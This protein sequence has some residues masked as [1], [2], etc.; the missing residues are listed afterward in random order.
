M[1]TITVVHF[2]ATRKKILAI[3]AATEGKKTQCKLQISGISSG[4]CDA[5]FFF[6]VPGLFEFVI[7]EPFLGLLVGDLRGDAG[8]LSRSV[9]PSPLLVDGRVPFRG[10]FET[11]V[12]V[13]D[14][15]GDSGAVSFV[16]F[17][18][19]RGTALAE[20]L[21]FGF[22][23]FCCSLV[24]DSER[25]SAKGI[26]RDDGTLFIFLLGPGDDGSSSSSP[27]AGN[28]SISSGA[29]SANRF[30]GSLFLK[31][32]SIGSSIISASFL[33][34]RTSRKAAINQNIPPTIAIY[35]PRARTQPTKPQSVDRNAIS[36][37]NDRNALN[38]CTA[39][40]G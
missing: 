17:D 5:F 30:S 12:R 34:T 4:D 24:A 13:E 19:D 28:A 39:I 15:R 22:G 10:D 33:R 2:F 18:D 31:S 16:R 37:M 7:A 20:L 27:G 3:S 40:R 25:G 9:S 35:P 26:S 32:I 29:G 38:T 14:G 8:R 1:T 23:D 6:F 36:N 21:R 11:L